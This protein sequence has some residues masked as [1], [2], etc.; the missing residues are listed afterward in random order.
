MI[1]VLL[2]ATGGE[3]QSRSNPALVGGVS[4]QLA[5]QKVMRVVYGLDV[6]VDEGRCVDVVDHEVEPAV[7]VEVGVCCAVRVAGLIQAPLTGLVGERQIT[8][9]SKYVTRQ[10]VTGQILQ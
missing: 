5:P 7:V 2:L 1:D 10:L 6:M 8:V 3:D 4:L 9:V